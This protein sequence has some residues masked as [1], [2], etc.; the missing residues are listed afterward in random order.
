MKERLQ[1]LVAALREACP[2]AGGEAADG[3]TPPPEA[4]M[5]ALDHMRLA[6]YHGSKRYC[7]RTRA[8]HAQGWRGPESVHSL[9]ACACRY[10]S[11]IAL[12]HAG[13]LGG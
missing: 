8:Y 7:P 11:C 5:E 4:L 9:G 13:V 3:A 12:T 10:V 1:A 6:S 2:R